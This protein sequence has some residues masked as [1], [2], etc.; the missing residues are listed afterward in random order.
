MYSSV[1]EHMLSM[2][3]ALDSIPSISHSIQSIK[4]FGHWETDIHNLGLK[5][6]MQWDTGAE[7]T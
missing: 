7:N 5:K 2:H 4:A 3:R 6:V 1:I